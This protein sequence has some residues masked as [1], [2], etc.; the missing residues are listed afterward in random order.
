MGLVALNYRLHAHESLASS[1]VR[2]IRSCAPFSW[3]SVTYVLGLPCY[4]CPRT[5]PTRGLT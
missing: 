2:C 1:S 5:I 3:S 4:L